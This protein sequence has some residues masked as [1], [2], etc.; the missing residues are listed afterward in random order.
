MQP[1]LLRRDDRRGVLVQLALTQQPLE[2][3]DVVRPE[4]AEEDEQV[5]A[6]DR[7]RRVELEVA[8]VP[9]DVEDPRGSDERAVEQLPRDRG[10]VLPAW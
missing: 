3:G 6:R 2:L 7:V 1:M 8:D 5:A 10:G 4:P 9:R